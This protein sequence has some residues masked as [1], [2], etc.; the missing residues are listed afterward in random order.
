MIKRVIDVVV[1]GLGLLLLFPIMVLLGIAIALESP[2]N[3]I[4]RQIRVGLGTK[5]F[6]IFKFRSMVIGADQDGPYFT[7]AGDDRITAVGA[8]L[9]R[10]SLDELPQLL[11]IVLGDMSLVGPR[12]DVPAQEPTYS[13]DQW[14]ERHSVRPGITG[15]AQ[16]TLRSQATPTDR[17][18][19]DLRYIRDRSIWLDLKII[20][21]TI[22]QIVKI[23][24]Y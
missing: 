17:L 10:T 14:K 11:N 16:S 23:G 12:P 7:Q 6:T 13:P 2:G 1:A 3:V 20:Y 5:P 8:F 18:E 24:S 21:C 22:I 4:F 15:L 9:R 19:L